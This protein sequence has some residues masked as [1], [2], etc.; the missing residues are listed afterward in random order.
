MAIIEIFMGAFVTVLMERLASRELMN[1]ARGEGIH[2]QLMKLKKVFMAVKAVLND[3]ETKQITE[4][5]V[6]LWLE[7]LRDLVYD[8]DD[9]LDEIATEAL[10]H[11]L[12]F[13]P[14]AATT[15]KVRNFLPICC[16]N[17]PRSIALK[18][19]IGPKIE[20]MTAR[21]Q[22][23]AKLRDDLGLRV[24]PEVRSN[25]ERE[26]LPT[27]SLVDETH[28]YGRE[29]EKQ[30]ILEWVLKDETCVIPIVGMGGVGKTTL[31]QLVYN[32]EKVEA[33]FDLKAWV[34][35]SEDFT[36]SRITKIILEAVSEKRCD[37]E[38]L[39]MLQ[40]NLKKELS[41][42]K[43]L[44]VLDDVWHENYED[45]DL[46]RAPFQVG[47]LGSKII[48][49]TRHERVARIMGSVRAY[50]LNVLAEVDCLSLLARHALGNTKFDDHPNLEVIGKEIVR[51][52]GR[53][54]LAAKTL[55]GLLH[56]IHSPNEWKAVLNSKIWEL[57]EHQSGILP[58]LRLSY[59]HL[60]S[61][62][63]QMFAYCAIF[64]KDY[65]FD[66]DELVLLWMAEGFLQQPTVI[67]SME[68]LGREYFDELLSRSFF[69]HSGGT[70]SKFVMHDLLNDLAQYVSGH[71][72]Y[73]LD[74]N[75]ES[76]ELCKIS[77]KA[78]HLSFIRHA[79]EVFKR[80]K[81]FHELQRLR[82]F[83]P[84]PLHKLRYWKKFYLSNSVLV[85]LLPKL[86]CLRVLS[87]S[88]YEISE[89]P[90]S[91]GD[92]KHLRYL[93]LSQTLIK[94]LPESVST[95]YN[96]QT[97]SVRG[98]RALC[99]LPTN[100]GNLVNLRHLDIR[101]TPKLEEMPS[102]ISRL[103]CLQ[104]FPKILLGKNSGFGL[105]DLKSLMLLRG[106]LSIFGLQN[107]MNVRDAKEAN[108][109]CKQNLNELEFKWNRDIED[110]QNEGLQ[111]RVLDMLRPHGE[112]KSLEIE[113]YRGI[114]FPRWIGD[115]A[116]SKTV[117]ISL[118]GCTKCK[119]L[120]PLGKLP[121][122][123][124]LYIEDMHCVK[125]VGSE[126]YSDGSTLEI[127]FPSLE[128][129]GFDQMPEWEDW[130][131]SYGIDFRG[132]FPCLRKLVIQNCPKLLSVPL[133]RLLSLRILEI[134][135][136][137][138][139][140][141]KSFTELPSLTTL[142]LTNISGLTHLQTE[143]MNVLVSLEVLQFWDCAAL[144]TLWQNGI[145]PK[146]LSHLLV[147]CENLERLPCGLKNLT[148]LKD[149]EIYYCPKLVSFPED[150]L[151]PMLR[152]LCVRDADSLESIPNCNTHLEVLKL[153]KCSSLRSL[154]VD[155][156]LSMLKSVSIEDC[157]NLEWVK[158][159]VE[160][161]IMS[162]SFGISN[163][164]NLESFIVRLGEFEYELKY[165][166]DHSLSGSGLLTPN[167]LSLYISGFE[168]PFSFPSQ[169]QSLTFLESLSIVNCKSLE[170]FPDQ[171]LPPNLETLVIRNCRELKPLS[172]WGLQRLSSLRHFTMEHVY[173]DLLSFP[174]SCFLPTT[175]KFLCIIG[176][177]N[178][179]SLSEGLQNLAFLE[180][181]KISNCP[182]IESLSEGLENLT[183]LVNLQIYDC[184]KVESLSGGL[185]KLTS[186]ESLHME[187]CPELGSLLN[188]RVL[189][190]L[191]ILVI[192]RCPLLKERY[193]KESGVD[194]PKIAH[195]PFVQIL[196]RSF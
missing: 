62:L 155:T 182:K 184:P 149:M 7:D 167:L 183:S 23:I 137:D 5:S 161:S 59:H 16:T 64:P 65:E 123:K 73:R 102:S 13:E 17:F 93:N 162:G 189:D 38:H 113:F 44:I 153:W 122:L 134:K 150:S 101:D 143:F 66:K 127:P 193:S 49:T 130:S 91:I 131:F 106:I 28:V 108:L 112:L 129:L 81:E 1:F 95:L 48:I 80:F 170:S 88:G 53:L 141:L 176:F 171:N 54:P 58:A 76:N 61:H 27:T 78:R 121:L 188:E 43:F 159:T 11:E 132:H 133:L 166:I 158:E 109:C 107:V 21:L 32:D 140:V 119:S 169:S 115:S 187:N 67:K 154:L 180:H 42:K 196:S 114:T 8:L 79:Y 19:K 174:D 36:V 14:E 97:L 39:D 52:C 41:K 103:K 89:L 20:E 163:W 33:L 116:F 117:Y 152:H 186:L 160:Q 138:E 12:K 86:W 60:P 165:R 135:N 96:L 164:P 71:I 50:P 55:G 192:R 185:Q 145:A 191:S 144:V 3:A 172:D 146:N 34:C 40:V 85:N 157:G 98:C 156:R 87:L 104:T 147:E 178:L 18:I 75:M 105:G 68:E 92:L 124:E 77:Q 142:I 56:N 31:A 74:D 72:C 83:L 57:S 118:K 194:W 46:L 110:S 175:L 90:N 99:K 190:T 9:L 179:E 148:S 126:F 177:S 26:R 69:Q 120:P 37:F 151:P 29:K 173:A 6:K 82:T 70:E 22:D 15:G 111:V 94:W 139:A 181:L 30:E 4:E 2:T 47:L 63:K 100:I 125:S 51:K 128:I 168:N 10:A 84:L 45:W 35:V 25:T 195:I 24:N 136:C